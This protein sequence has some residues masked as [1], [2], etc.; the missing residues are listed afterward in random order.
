MAMRADVVVAGGG[1]IGSTIALYLARAGLSVVVADPAA[2]GANASGVAAGMLA[3]AFEA[4]FDEVSRDRFA[5]LRQARDLWPSL[6][7]ELGLTL[8]CQGALAVGSR[9]QVAEWAGALAGFGADAQVQAPN[10]TAAATPWLSGGWS[11]RT[12]DDWR[13]QPVAALKALRC[14]A[15]TSG[16]R[17]T[18]DR[19]LG[20][21][22]GRVALERE[23][24]VAASKL[25]LASGASAGL[26]ALAPE[27]VRL[28]PI[29]GHIL[30]T[31]FASPASGP[32]LRGAGVYLCPTRE[33]LILG[34]TMEVGRGDLEIDPRIVGDLI[35]QAGRLSAGL[36]VLRWDAAVGVRGE[37]PDGLPMAG[38]GSAPDVLL[39]V[40]A[41]RN[42]WLLA[43]L[44]AKTLLD[45]IENGAPGPTARLFDPARPSVSRSPS[46]PG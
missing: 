20:M 34:A 39:A 22:D 3:P 24:Q 43:P 28:S 40:G 2:L 31:R 12:T 11:V 23:G 16:V 25:V 45:L 30:R 9:S 27:L 42:G 18:V 37:T 32:V 19:V 33:E 35:A 26:A 36:K 15:E 21:A 4:L 46:Q 41:R 17:W 8:D 14:A 29:K 6:A 5:L 38:W 44:I 7:D 10:E 1:A 13:L